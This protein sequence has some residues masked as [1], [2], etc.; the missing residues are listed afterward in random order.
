MRLIGL[1]VATILTFAPLAAE[2]QQPRR[3]YRIGVLTLS[4]ASST[5]AVSDAALRQARGDALA[6]TTSVLAAPPSRAGSSHREVERF[7][8]CW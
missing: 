7:S 4:M 5:P 8:R 6:A 2:G 1:V 3:M